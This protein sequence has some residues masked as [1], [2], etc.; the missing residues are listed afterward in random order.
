MIGATPLGGYV[1]IAGMIDESMDTEHLDEEPKP[2]EFRS[3]PVWQRMVVISAGVIFNMILAFFI[4]TGL[5][6]TYGED[7]IP[8]ENVGPMY[9]PDSSLA[10][11]I[12]FETGDEVI[13]VNGQRVIYYKELIAPNNVT[14]SDLSYMVRRGETTK[15]IEVPPGFLDQLNKNQSFLSVFYA[16]PSQ[17]GQVVDDTPADRAGLKQGDRIVAIDSQKVDYWIEL[18]SIIK[19]ADDTLS[20]QVMRGGDR[21]TTRLRPDPE[22]NTI[23]IQAVNPYDYFKAET[24]NPGFIASFGRGATETRNIFVGIIQSFKQLLVGNVSVRESLGGPVAIATVTKDVTDQAG[25]E[26]FWRITA[27]LSITLAIMNILPIPVLDGGHLVF[28]LY[29]GVTRREPS[30]K[31]RMILQQIGFVLLIG[32][33]LFATFNDIMRLL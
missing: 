22:T 16:L 7:V 8:V 4:Y 27:M 24:K 29:E 6:F 20:M 18:T 15:Q 9:V 32:L 14:A 26:G 11:Q 3:K 5:S 23:G 21:I 33:I 13:G 2:Y 30:E 1:K 17:V 25:L 19:A 31:V 10:R 12:G 28:L